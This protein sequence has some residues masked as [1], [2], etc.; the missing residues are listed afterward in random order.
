VNYTP[1]GLARARAAFE[2]K[3]AIVSKRDITPEDVL[4]EILTAYGAGKLESQVEASK[5]LIRTYAQNKD[6][7]R[8]VLLAALDK[9]LD[10]CAEKGLCEPSGDQR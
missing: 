8:A 7:S 5:N 2:G 4:G 6:K 9:A 10:L 3:A 1:E